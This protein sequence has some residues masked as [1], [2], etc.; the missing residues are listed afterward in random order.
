MAGKD[1]LKGHAS[2]SKAPGNDTAWSGESPGPYIGVVKNNIDPLRMGRLQVNIPSLSKTLDPVSGNLVTCEYLSPFYGAKDARHSIPGSTDYKDSQHSYGFWAVPP[3]IGTRV[4]VIFAEGKMDQ[5][6]W[7]GCVPD[8]MTNQMT[9]GIA[10]STSTHDALDGTFEG[11][12]AGFQDDKKSKYGTTNVPSGEVNRTVKGLKPE[13]FKTLRRPIHP[14]AET[15]LKQ[16]LSADDIRGNTSSSARRESPS[17]VFGISTPGRKDRGT[18]KVK[19]GTKDSEATDY[20]TRKTGHTFVMD[21]GAVDGTN[22]LTRLRTASGHQ[23]LMHD[24]EGVV[25]IANGSGNAYIEMQKNG[26]IDVYSGVGGIN[27]RTEGDMNFHSDLNMNFHANGQVRMS[28]A[29]EMIQSAD[30]LLTIGEKGILQSSPAG[31][32]QNYALS[33]ISSFTPG[34]QLHGALGQFHLQGARIDLNLPMGGTGDDGEQGI[35][36]WGPA[37]LTQEKVGMQ[38]REEGDVELAGKGQRPLKEFTRKTKTT[39]HRFVTHE[40][41]FRASVISGDSIIPVDADDKK[42]WSRLANTPGTPE[43]INQQLRLN[44]NSAIRHAIYQE[45]AVQWVKQNAG[46]SPNAAKVKELLTELGTTYNDIYGISEKLNLPFDIKDSISE[47]F[48]GLD[49]NSPLKD[50]TSNL[51]S[52]VVEKFTGKS[53]ELFKDN[54]FVNSAGELYTLGSNTISGISGNIDLLNSSLNS[55]QGLTKNLSSGNIDGTIANLNSITQTYKSVVGG[56]IVG[57]N[58]VKSLARKAGLFDAR[59]AARGGQTFLQNVGVN[60][61]NKIGNI[62]GAVKSFFTTRFS[63]ARLKKDIKLISRSPQGINI[64]EFKYIHTDGTYEGVMAQE[65]PWARA[66]TD[67]GYY[68]V[69]YSKVD[70]EFRRL[71]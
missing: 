55:V 58:Q 11:A 22:Q 70:V 43:Y 7:I 66:M 41:M 37:W 63:D 25:Y 46:D 12:D 28:S 64:Y 57:M 15:L 67:T 18:T 53:T 44:E 50:L 23:L 9:P 1:Y 59:D 27:L 65:V 42:Q 19:V 62:G 38:L 10:S 24:T 6:F 33:S 21:D 5:A 40:P 32:I 8:P 17:Q 35:A 34:Q 49:F 68:M 31:G 47:K 30:V 52:Q 2:T 26:R 29:K 45:D 16:G 69:D 48:K 20:V 14:F 54:V 71:N 39:V 51:T 4:L 60:L 13:Q 56:Q 3:D 61:S 36:K